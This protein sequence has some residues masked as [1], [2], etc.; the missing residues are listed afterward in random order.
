[1]QNQKLRQVF[2]HVEKI[3]VEL[4]QS[5]EHYRDLN[6]IMMYHLQL[7][8]YLSLTRN[9]MDK[10]F[11]MSIYHVRNPFAF[12][13]TFFETITLIKLH[14]KRAVNHLVA[15]I[16]GRLLVT[17]SAAARNQ[18]GRSRESAARS[19]VAGLDRNT[20]LPCHSAHHQ[21]QGSSG[22]HQRADR[23]SAACGSL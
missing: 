1:M 19:K 14:E 12:L 5:A 3:R 22:G 17:Y 7:I 20:G 11:T 21:L 6:Y 23:N 18:H 15:N 8:S 4:I 2:G 13:S 9:I 16:I 10:L